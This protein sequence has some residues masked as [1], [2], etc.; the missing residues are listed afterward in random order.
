M[1]RWWSSARQGEGAGDPVRGVEGIHSSVG[2]PRALR[3]KD[4]WEEGGSGNRGQPL[5]GWRGGGGS[6]QFLRPSAWR[7][8]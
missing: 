8:W 1:S 2:P 6:A 3:R 5:R 7:R 4:G